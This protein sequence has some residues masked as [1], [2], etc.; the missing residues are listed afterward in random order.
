[1]TSV[2]VA[3]VGLAAVCTANLVVS[4]LLFRQLGV[5]LMGTTRGV[6][7]SGIPLGRRFPPLP[8]EDGLSL[9]RGYVVF[10]I[11]THCGECRKMIPHMVA[12]A[13]ASEL[14]LVTLLVGDESKVGLYSSRLGL[15]EPVIYL[16]GETAPKFDIEFTPFGYAV[17]SRGVVVDKS[18]V[19]SEH[20]ARQLF[21]AALRVE[22]RLGGQRSDLS[23]SLS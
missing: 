18:L 4:A 19:N 15:P 8:V 1:M 10:V 5:V 6:Q 17:D 14:P 20:Q 21:Q 2:Q 12:A 16:D 7:Q 9:Q 11:S 23:G 3:I 22:A 13:N